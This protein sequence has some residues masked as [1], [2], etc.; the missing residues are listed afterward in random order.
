MATHCAHLTM[1]SGRRNLRGSLGTQQQRTW[2]EADDFFCPQNQP[3]ENR[4]V[5]VPMSKRKI[6]KVFL[7]LE[8][9]KK[10]KNIRL[11]FYKNQNIL[12]V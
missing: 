12:A 9:E 7:S 11:S 10:I 1:R 4:K 8:V 5:F 3:E 6:Q 2:P